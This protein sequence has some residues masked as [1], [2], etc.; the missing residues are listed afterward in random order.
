MM[1]RAS[2][3]CSVPLALSG[4]PA[5]PCQGGILC[6]YPPLAAALCIQPRRLSPSQSTQG[7]IP[8]PGTHAP[9]STFRERMLSKPHSMMFGQAEVNS[10]L[11]PWKFS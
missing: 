11:L 6:P 3:L 5:L 2:P 8:L 1:P 10:I 9:H 7:N 4:L